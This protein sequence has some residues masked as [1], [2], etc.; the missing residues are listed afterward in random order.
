MPKRDYKGYSK[1]QLIEKIKKLEKQRYG[2]IWDNKPEDVAIQ[3][4]KEIPILKEVKDKEIKADPSPDAPVNLLIEGDNYHALYA[5]S[6]SL[7]RKVDIIFIDPPYNTGAKNWKYNNCY[8]DSTDP[9]RHSKWLSFMYKRLMLSK[10]LLSDCGIIMVTIDD[11]EVAP[12]TMLLNFLFG[13]SNHLGTIV[14]ESKAEGR[15]DDKFIATAHEYLLVYSKDSNNAI[16]NGISISDEEKYKKY[17][18]KDDISDYGLKPFRRGG[19][20]SRRT[21]RPNLYYPVFFSPK[22]NTISL[23][24]IKDSTKIIPIDPKGVERVWQW[25]QATFNEN[26]ETE[27]VVVQNHNSL[28]IYD[29]MVKRRVK[30]SK[31][32]TS[33]WTSPKYNT[34]AHGTKLLEKILGVNRAFEYPKSLYSV[35]DAIYIASKENSIIVDFFAG[36]GTTG[37]AVLELNKSD[38]GKRQFILCTNN[39]N[40]ICEEVCYPRINKVIEGYEGSDPLPANV[41]YYK[42]DFIPNIL[43]DQDKRNL[44]NHSTELICIAENTYEQVTRSEKDNEFSIF[45]NRAQYTVII[46]D[47]DVIDKCINAIKK[48][49]GK[50]EFVIYVFS[51]DNEYNAE[52]FQ[53]LTYKYKVKP[54]P[55]TILNVYRRNTKRKA[56]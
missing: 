7:K 19:A 50:K 16:L 46:Y 33:V 51:Y 47:E 10:S 39:E 3:C 18:F 4:D 49:D 14:I 13:E 42:T 2:L 27:L 11:Y 22:T 38:R 52:D 28:Q 23:D 45:E 20:N 40:N 12:L 43:T 24:Y 32:P 1:E 35:K 21:D 9:Y 56:R 41:K 34:A 15:T 25:G 55:E 29:V 6:F 8:V 53:D 37:H 26:K 31:K 48:L 5:L 36:S 54:I 44:V 17:P 30:S